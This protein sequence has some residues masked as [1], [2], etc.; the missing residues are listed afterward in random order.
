MCPHADDLDGFFILEAGALQAFDVLCPL[1]GENDPPHRLPLQ[2]IFEN[3]VSD[4]PV[5]L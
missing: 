5:L 1:L 3:A 2:F 4:C